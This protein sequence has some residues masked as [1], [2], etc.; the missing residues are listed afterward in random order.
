MTLAKCLLALTGALAVASACFSATVAQTAQP[1]PG[2]Q[3][4][5]YCELAQNPDA[6]NH[7]LLR[8]TAFVTHGFEDFHLADVCANRQQHF[9][10]WVTYGGTTKSE[11]V[12]CCSNEDTSGSRSQSLAIEGIEIPVVESETF[13]RFQELLRKEA[14]TAVRVTVVGRFFA[15]DKATTS[16]VSYWRGYGHLGCCSLFVV[17]QLESFEPHSRQ[18]VDYTAEA[19]WYESEGCK[20]RSMR[21]L[22]HVSI[23]DWHGTAQQAVAEQQQA[24]G[25]ERSW[26]LDDAERV[27]MES[28]KPF[29]NGQVPALRTV[30][31]TPVREVFRWKHA[32]KSTVVV[33]T[34]PYWLSFYAD[35][36][37]V[38]WIATMIK[39][40]DCN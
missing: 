12:H 34:R 26:A 3:N 8:M 23:D 10:V 7:A 9:S 24:N 33:V 17:Q 36:H 31:K 13:R 27:A 14:D 6:F 30:K 39:E 29:Y 11:T 19:G 20:W 2:V 28:L 21:D 37:T 40:A 15:G 22:R 32:K 16:G 5:T 18:D 1:S 35:G 4:I 38:A 25:G